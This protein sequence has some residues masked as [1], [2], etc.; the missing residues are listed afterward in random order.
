MKREKAFGRQKTILLCK[1]CNEKRLKRR[2]EI[3]QIR[4][5][6]NTGFFPNAN[7]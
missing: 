6:S 5:V 1:S 3:D 2:A 7:W 4:D